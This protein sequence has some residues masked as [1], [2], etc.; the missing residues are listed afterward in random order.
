M[1]KTTSGKEWFKMWGE[2]IDRV[3]KRDLESAKNRDIRENNDVNENHDQI[4]LF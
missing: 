1:K 2:A 4:P 3:D